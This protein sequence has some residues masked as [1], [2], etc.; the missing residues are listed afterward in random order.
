KP[1]AVLLL[2]HC[3]FP[4]SPTRTKTGIAIDVLDFY[5][6]LFE[7]SCDA[8]TVLAAALHTVY[9]WWGFKVLSDQDEH[10][11]DP[12]CRLLIQTFQWATNL[13][14]CVEKKVAV[15]LIRAE[16]QP[17]I[18][19]LA[20]LIDGSHPPS[21]PTFAAST[22][23]F[24]ASATS[25]ATNGTGPPAGDMS[26]GG[27]VQLGADGCFSYC[28]MRKAGDSPISY[29]PSFF[30][31]KHKVDVVARKI[32]AAR[33]RPT[34]KV[35]PFMPQEVIDTCQESWDIANENKRK[36]DPKHHDASSIFM[37]CRHR[38]VLFLCNIDTPGE[39]QR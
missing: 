34:A 5:C 31:P 28:H 26:Y 1:A 3:V 15:V 20:L 23:A 37:T 16:L 39:Q 12:F 30:I 11:S 4:V 29:D 17:T 38:Q 6:A 10:A 33:K 18:P 22:A 36:A 9:E 19:V 35:K 27:N 24:V 21:T 2:E 7:R 8:I 25:S 32:D 14:D 13:R